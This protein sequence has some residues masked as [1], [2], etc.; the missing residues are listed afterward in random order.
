MRKRVES[1][2]GRGRSKEPGD[3]QI[4]VGMRKMSKGAG[5]ELGIQV[6]GGAWGR[7][8]GQVMGRGQRGEGQEGGARTRTWSELEAWRWASSGRD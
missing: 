7:G 4:L 3:R 6:V 5:P 1:A 8:H 2:H